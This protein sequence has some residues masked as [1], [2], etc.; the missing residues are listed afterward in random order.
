MQIGNRARAHSDRKAGQDFLSRRFSRPGFENVSIHS[1]GRPKARLG[2]PNTGIA[3]TLVQDVYDIYAIN[4][5][6]AS[7]T[8]IL[9]TQP[10]NSN[11]ANFG[12]TAFNKTY[13]HTNLT[14]QGQL[15]SSYTFILRAI[16]IH[17]DPL[18]G[19]THPV[20]PHVED[21]VNFGM[22]YC[23]LDVN[24]KP[25]LRSRCGWLPQSGGPAFGGIGTLTAPVSSYATTNGVPYAKNAYAIYGGLFILPQENF[26]FII[27]PTKSAGGVWSTVAQAGVPTGVLGAGIMAT[28]RLLGQM[29]RVA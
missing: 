17:V 23:E 1:L 24:D 6:T 16:S 11:Y 3:E 9:F 25:W 19:L 28:V 22:T 15:A 20:G 10:L 21:A 18:Q 5:A 29:T 2:N 8:L 14:Q 13:C 4:V 26:S 12:V 7:G 27:D